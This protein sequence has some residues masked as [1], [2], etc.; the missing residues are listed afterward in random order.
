MDERVEWKKL[1][2]EEH[3][4]SYRPIIKRVVKDVHGIEKNRNN[5]K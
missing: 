5:K 1:H 4:C 3:H 2:Y